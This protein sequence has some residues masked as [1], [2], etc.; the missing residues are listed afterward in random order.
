VA[1]GPGYVAAAAARRGATVVGV[2]FSSAMVAE[3]AS[4]HPGIEFR[5]G[6]AESLPFPDESFDAVVIAFGLLHFP[7]PN[8]ALAE[9]HRVLRSG[10]KLGF[11]VWAGPD[12]A[13]GFGLIIKAIQAHG[14]LDAG[15]PDGPPFFRFS[16]P[17]EAGRTLTGLGFISP[18]SREIAQTWRFSSAYEWI[19][20]IE[21]YT[22]RTAALLRAQNSEAR[23]AIHAAL[24]AAAQQ[25]YPGKTGGI[26]IPMPAMLSSAT[27]P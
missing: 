8:R 4:R 3:A 18:L 7:H 15:L 25:S 11:T 22:V 20:G 5:E 23:A 12:R 19:G 27:K 13:V 24:I 16:D 17:E 9:A 26:E 1:S 21:T 2:D 6:N 10:G 14:N